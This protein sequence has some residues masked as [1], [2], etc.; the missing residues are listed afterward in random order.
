MPLGFGKKDND[1][2]QVAEKGGY[3]SR[4]QS[5]SEDAYVTECQL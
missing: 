1:K 2:E 5:W 4:S 3:A